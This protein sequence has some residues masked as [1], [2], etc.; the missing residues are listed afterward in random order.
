MVLF[1]GTF[2]VFP[3]SEKHEK[4]FDKVWHM[5]LTGKLWMKIMICSVA[6]IEFICCRMKLWKNKIKTKT[7]T[8]NNGERE[9]KPT[10]TDLFLLQQTN[11]IF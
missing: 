8:K 7:K 6:N 5:S 2:M 4:L 11:N 3:L 1:L 10:Q 9:K